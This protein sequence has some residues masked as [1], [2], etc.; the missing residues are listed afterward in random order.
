MAAKELYR[1]L[2]LTYFFTAKAIKGMLTYK[3]SFLANCISQALDYSVTFLLMWIM[4][5][6]FR[7]MNGW[8]AYEVML[9][10]AF[11]LFAYG[12]AGTFF[13]NI[14]N[15]VP[16]QILKGAFDDVL[17][18]PVK[19]LPYLMSSSFICNYIAHMT[20]SAIVMAVCMKML[21]LPLTLRFLGTAAGILLCG[22]LIYAG[23]FLIV[24]ASAFLAAKIDV[25]FQVMYFFRETSY[26][27]VSIFPRVIQ[28]IVTILVPYGF[29][30]YYPLR[31]FLKKEDNAVFGWAA[32]WGPF[33]S[34]LFFAVSCFIFVK[35]AKCYKS[36][37][38]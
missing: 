35:C 11:S 15:L 22:S 34:V 24:T 2:R 36:S 33:V 10:Y 23:L 20:L 27:P 14:M 8:N 13:F 31:A 16:G 17:V 21:K 7:T 4:I 38:S 9:L 18:K 32:A 19:I 6:A 12:I 3:W 37:G 25:L 29:V 30:N 5:S 26:Y 28:V 1:Y